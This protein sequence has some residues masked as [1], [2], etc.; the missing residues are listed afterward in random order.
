MESKE[1]S[2][3]EALLA[4][5]FCKESL[6]AAQLEIDRLNN[7]LNAEKQLKEELLHDRDDLAALVVEL[8]NTIF[9]LDS[10][11]Q[12]ILRN[13]KTPPV[14]PNQKVNFSDNKNASQVI[15]DREFENE[16]IEALAE[17]L[18]SIR[19][20]RSLLLKENKIQKEKIEDYAE[21]VNTQQ[22]EIL[23]LGRRIS[24]LEEPL[25]EQK[26]NWKLA[27]ENLGSSS[28]IASWRGVSEPLV[29][30]DIPPIKP[31]N[32]LFDAATTIS[33]SSDPDNVDS[34]SKSLFS[35]ESEFT[36]S[37]ITSVDVNRTIITKH[38]NKTSNFTN[39][40]ND[41]LRLRTIPRGGAAS[42]IISS[43]K[44][45]TKKW[46]IAGSTAPTIHPMVLSESVFLSDLED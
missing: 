1:D 33:M 42:N 29:R 36:G 3:D 25:I 10:E 21:I 31:F 43:I 5:E 39:P 28:P 46:G 9:E 30:N 4:L 23:E 2:Y 17:E 24:E 22:S 45:R 8:E 38:V 26:S 6:D 16:Y 37:D 32:K 14:S 44:A 13:K 41:G 40:S 12:L 34:D 18:K 19:K 27:K 20:E 7:E 35:A 11:Y 15:D